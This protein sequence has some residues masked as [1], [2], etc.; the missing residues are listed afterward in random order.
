MVV[1]PSLPGVTLTF[2]ARFGD[3]WWGA[4]FRLHVL[5]QTT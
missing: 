5:W 2:H 4:K 3:A 1:F